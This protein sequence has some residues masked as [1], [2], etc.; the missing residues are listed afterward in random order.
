MSELS[1]DAIRH[2]LNTKIFGQQIIYVPQIGSTNTELKKLAQ[3]GT[4]E[5]TLY[6]TDEQVTGRGRLGR[7]WQAPAG[8]SLLMSLLFRPAGIISPRQTQRL[9]MLCSLALVDAV[10][11]ET[12]VAPRLKW[13]NDLVWTDGKKLAGVL[14]EFGIEGDAL[15]W[16]IVGMGMNV[17]IEF[18]TATAND[19][20]ATNLSDVAT[21]LSTILGRDTT[22]I[23]LPIVRQFL[24]NVEQRYNDLKRGQLPH[25][26]W[27]SRL[28]G[29]GEPTTVTNLD[30]SQHRGII[31]GVNDDG[32]LLL[33]QPDGSLVTVWAGDVTLRPTS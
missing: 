30:G 13:P 1:I 33:K 21:S 25:Q 19:S 11:A 5:G 14:T 31:D 28:T 27:G 4:V 32:A 8:S 24:V 26:D 6:L 2:Q 16:V 29:I 23:R 15:S 18:R 10:E 17:N 20:E 12:G 9:T 3:T 7:T 22:E